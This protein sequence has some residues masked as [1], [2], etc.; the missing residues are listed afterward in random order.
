METRAIY[1]RL[2]YSC[3]CLLFFVRFQR[4]TVIPNCAVKGMHAHHPRSCLFYMRDWEITRLQ[5]LLQE[6][7]VDYK[8]EARRLLVQG[9]SWVCTQA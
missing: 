6:N 5:E 1:L 9:M 2:V 8:A 3:F 4:C 7:G